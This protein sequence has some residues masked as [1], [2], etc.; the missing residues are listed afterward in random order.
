[1]LRS[2][3]DWHVAARSRTVQQQQ[4]QNSTGLL[5]QQVIGAPTH[6]SLSQSFSLHTLSLSSLLSSLYSQR[7]SR[8]KICSSHADSLHAF[9]SIVSIT[10]N[11]QLVTVCRNGLVPS[12][13]LSSSSCGCARWLKR[14]LRLPLTSLL[15]RYSLMPSISPLF[16]TGN[17]VLVN[18]QINLAYLRQPLSLQNSHTFFFLRIVLSLSTCTRRSL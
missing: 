10:Q 11:H 5:L 12:L 7:N 6:S 18:D 13:H 2:A 15:V 3:A 9:D 17:L 1:M 4:Q 16:R 14:S 8:F